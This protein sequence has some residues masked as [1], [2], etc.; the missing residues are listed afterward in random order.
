MELDAALEAA[1]RSGARRLAAAALGLGLATSS[2][3]AAGADPASA[4]PEGADPEGEP[5]AETEAP[6]DPNELPPLP[7]PGGQPQPD[8]LRRDVDHASSRSRRWHAVLTASPLYASFRLPFLGRPSVPVR[9]GGF[10][11]SA[12]VPVW[13]PFGLRV[14]ASHTVH[15]VFDELARAE[16][17]PPERVARRGLVQATHAGVSATFALDIG[18]VRPTLD[19]GVGGLWMRSPE[20][21]QDGQ[22]GGECLEGG[23]CDTGLACNAENMCV[24]GVVPQV[25]GGF[26]VDVMIADRFA[27]G[28]ELRY[29]A[30][31]AAPTSYPVYLLAGLR[32]SLRF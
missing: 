26:S 24:A 31:I 5:A 27:V 8:S 32:A 7:P 16:D 22:L 3:V 2:P 9:G 30:L 10:G 11:L 25:H 13:H 19:A 18:R 12:M 23:G 17:E 1:R 6:R 28:G 4:T 14:A 29:F 20:A 15:P 21:V